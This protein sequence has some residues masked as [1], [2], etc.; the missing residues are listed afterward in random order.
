MRIGNGFDVHRFSEEEHRP[1]WLGLVEIPGAR[2]LQGH[3]DADAVTHAIIDALLGAVGEGDIGQ[4]FPESD[5][6]IRGISSREMLVHALRIVR[7]SGFRVVNVDVTV[8]AETP[9]LAP[10]RSDICQVLSEAIGAPV[11]L[12]ATTME[13]LGSIGARE[14]LA[15]LAVCL[16]EE[17]S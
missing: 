10:H 7:D 9:R 16:V 5:P 1:L 15:A 6:S 2:G 17:I 4:H 12:K 8:V 11:S 13:G 14:A 3:S